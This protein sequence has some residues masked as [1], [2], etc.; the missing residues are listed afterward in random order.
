MLIYWLN[1][2]AVSAVN[3]C[4]NAWFRVGQV[5]KWNTPLKCIA[6]TLQVCFD[7]SKKDKSLVLKSRQQ[8]ALRKSHLVSRLLRTTRPSSWTTSSVLPGRFTRCCKFNFRK[9]LRQITRACSVRLN[10]R[11]APWAFLLLQQ[12]RREAWRNDQDRGCRGPSAPEKARSRS[13][14]HGPGSWSPWPSQRPHQRTVQSTD[15][16]VGAKRTGKLNSDSSLLHL[17]FVFLRLVCI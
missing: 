9:S 12:W 11:Q 7:S 5:S 1:C 2:L 13:R 6:Q 15:F 3:A 8:V 16:S 10:S 14:G 17:A 4:R